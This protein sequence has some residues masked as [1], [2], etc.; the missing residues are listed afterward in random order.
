MA[1][2]RM[3]GWVVDLGRMEYGAALDWQR[4][5]HDA[6]RDGIVPDTLLLV[7]HDPVFTV[8]RHAMGSHANVL[9]SDEQ[10]RE[11]GVALYDVDRGGDA[12][13][14][15]P[16]QLVG[17]PIL[18]LE[19]HGHDLLAYLRDLEQAFI[20]LLADYDLVGQRIV[21]HTGV[22]VGTQK[23]VAIGVKASQRVTS[24]GFAFNIDP[25]LSHFEGIIP[26]GI[27]DKGVTSLARLT[28]RRYTLP[29]LRQPILHHLGPVLSLAWEPVALAALAIQV[30]APALVES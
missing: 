25:N 24:H 29:D 17:Y 4:R 5:V 12:T 18:H 3:T 28:G 15:G 14:H 27:A 26:C 16:G 19:R 10:R 11:R 20:N 7:E 21:P 23:V 8:G 13:Y 9:W 2:E 22:W 6:V 1:S 30:G